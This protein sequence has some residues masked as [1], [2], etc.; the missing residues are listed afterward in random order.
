MRFTDYVE[1]T[2]LS[3]ARQLIAALAEQ[4]AASV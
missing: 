3:E 1:V 2:G 4:I